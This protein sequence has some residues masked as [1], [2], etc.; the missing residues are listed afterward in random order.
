M[1]EQEEKLK[2]AYAL[3][4]CKVSLSQI[5]AY[6]DINI[7]KQEYNMIMNNLNIEKIPKDEALLDALRSIMDEI[8]YQLMDAGDA[9]IVE[10]EYQSQ[11]KNAIWS[12]VPNV[13]V[14][15]GGVSSGAGGTSLK[16]IGKANAI[17]A[18][19]NLATVVGIGY[20]NYRKNKAENSLN[21]EKEKWQIE[22]NRLSHLNGVKQ[23]FFATT[24][25]LADAYGFPDDY[26]LN[27]DQLDAYNQ[28]LMDTNL[29]TRYEKLDYMK[30]NF[31]A[32]P[33]FWYYIGN[34]AN[35]IYRNENDTE[36]K[37]KYRSNA[38]MCFD[39]YH[40]LNKYN[41]LRSDILTASWALEYLELL[42]LNA[43][44]QPEKAADLIH[45]AEK[46]SGGTL[47]ICELCAFAYLR[48]GYYD[49]AIRLFR[50]LVSTHYN[51]AIN[52]QILSALYI[53]KIVSNDP[54]REDYRM[55]YEELPSMVE[56]YKDYIMELPSQGNDLSEWEPEWNKG[57]SAEE[58][59]AEEE[60]KASD[61]K[62]E[63]DRRKSKAFN[64]YREKP[65]CLVYNEDTE[66]I[67][68]D[69]L[70]IMQNNYEKIKMGNTG[71]SI[72]T[73][74]LESYK[75][76]KSDLEKNDYRMIF[77]GDSDEAKKIYNSTRKAKWDE[78]KYGM[79]YVTKGNKTVLVVRDL[80]NWE[81]DKFVYFAKE[82]RKKYPNEV[83]PD[84]DAKTVKYTFLKKVF[85]DSVD[86][87]ASLVGN[88]IAGVVLSPLLIVGQAL[89]TFSNVV[90]KGVNFSEKKE[91]E[92]LRYR[93]TACL[94][95]DSIGVYVE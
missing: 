58:L 75:K 48:I 61:K 11:M 41:L 31:K 51:T 24:W 53:K 3:N 70:A 93:I 65:I 50:H 23:Q 79:R 19:V 76:E 47:D 94:Y 92:N 78:N 21:Y 5:I 55:E 71:C 95:L 38:I 81:I 88:V 67:V 42:D 44:N 27:D 45:I 90:Q 9:K 12:A 91:L 2:A 39:K 82:A 22:R 43:E 60:K 15:V 84:S 86:D 30:S 4:L 36:K 25:H 83:F 18:A 33:I 89:E 13:A 63:N 52:T 57:K 14:L 20:M 7:L 66:K 37:K 29:Y 68:E 1:I 6:D 40:E 74:N 72:C 59:L 77:I 85:E 49:D 64:Y 35:Q 8:T 28:A 10:M 16:G 87:A 17:G 46:Y 32:Y 26:R 54:R 62:K 56:D 80:R 69:I 34:T 73:K